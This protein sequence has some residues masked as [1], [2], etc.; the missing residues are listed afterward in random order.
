MCILVIPWKLNQSMTEAVTWE[1]FGGSCHCSNAVVS[2]MRQ[3]VGLI[4]RK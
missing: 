2:G 1:A 4:E 3:G